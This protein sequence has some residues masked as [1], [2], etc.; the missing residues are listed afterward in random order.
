M[1]K[2]KAAILLF[3][4]SSSILFA[5]TKEELKESA[6]RDAKIASKATLEGD[7]NLVLKHTYPSVVEMMGGKEKA[8]QI[9]ASMFEEMTQQGFVFEKAEVEFV[10]DVVFEQNEY[11]CYTQ[12]MNVMKMNKMIIN[13]KS[14]L[15]G[16][17]DADKK[18]WYFIEAEKM[19]NTALMNQL[20]PDFETS[21]I[22]PEDEM[23]MEE[24]KD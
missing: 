8:S 1:N 21:L 14:Y 3:V 4:V 5:Q 19:K 20:F 12:S 6:L 11:R 24:I 22:V 9:V 15:F 7:Y 16:F 18:Y 23:K 13:S 17:Y 2:F 10:S